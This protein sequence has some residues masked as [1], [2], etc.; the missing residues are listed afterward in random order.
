[1]AAGL[2]IFTASVNGAAK[3]FN[4]G[5]DSAG[6]LSPAHTL[7]D[8]FGLPIGVSGNELIVKDVIAEAALGTPADSV[9]TAGAGSV[10]A[11]LKA[12]ASGGSA[13]IAPIATA[14]LASSLV[15]KAGA[16]NLYGISVSS[17]TVGGWI[18]VFDATTLP[19]DGLVTPKYAWPL[20]SPNGFATFGF[21]TPAA[22]ATG[23]VVA[24]STTGPL[25][26]AASATAFITGQVR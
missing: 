9:W 4:A 13:A 23:I 22:F 20:Q 8:Q 2:T 25:T 14:V 15:L 21:A 18:L 26:L 7:L 17:T 19:P 10:V 16:G 5:Q 6:N 12:I 3:L 24:F 1:M 11:L